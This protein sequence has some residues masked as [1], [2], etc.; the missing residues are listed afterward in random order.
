MSAKVSSQTLEHTQ[1]TQLGPSVSVRAC[2]CVIL[3]KTNSQEVLRRQPFSQA[4]HFKT[5]SKKHTHIHTHT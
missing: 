3:L 4:V 5:H 2:V 1:N